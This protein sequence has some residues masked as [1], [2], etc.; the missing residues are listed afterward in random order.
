MNQ[1]LITHEDS[2][3]LAARKRPVLLDPQP[4]DMIMLMVFGWSIF[5]LFLL[6]GG[7][8][9]I[10]QIAKLVRRP[11]MRQMILDGDERV[12]A[13]LMIVGVVGIVILVLFCY[14][15]RLTFAAMAWFGTVYGASGWAPARSLAFPLKYATF[16]FLFVFAG[17]FLLKNFWRLTASP[18][19]RLML[20]YFFWVVG[21]SLAVGGGTTNDLWYIITDLAYVVGFGIAWN[22]HTNDTEKINQYF[23]ALAYTSV[24]VTFFHAI[25]PF[26]HTPYITSGRFHSI[27]GKATGF[28][29]GYAPFVLCLYWMG[30]VH[31]TKLIQ[32]FFTSAALLG[33]LLIFWSGTRSAAAAL[34]C[35]IVVLWWVFRGRI[36]IY[37]FFGA[38]FALLTQII[39]GPESVDITALSSRLQETDSSN[40]QGVW[41][42][43]WGIILNS[44]IYGH[45]LGGLG[46]Q[47]IGEA[48]AS[49]IESYGRGVRYIGAHNA[50]IG[51]TAKFGVIG[52]VLFLSLI[53]HA[54]RPAWT[55][56]FSRS[57]PI[58][59][60]R[61][62]VLAPALVILMCIANLA[63]E[64][65]GSRGRGTVYTTIFYANLIFCALQGSRLLTQY[66]KP[67]LRTHNVEKPSEVTVGDREQPTNNI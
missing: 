17:M 60:K 65:I 36:F 40:R 18:Y 24:A 14:K 56:L 63:E 34:L 23:Y 44:P 39:A 45:G 52:L 1:Q 10:V 61:V 42:Q 62:Y 4:G 41:T 15:Y 11:E 6:A 66:N 64:G 47:F 12:L 59:E 25:A 33:T 55:V 49:L 16:A 13:L 3:A 9:F 53:Y 5:C 26:V 8:R 48:W 46:S 37:I 7:R 35:S 28:G 38:V 54:L 32:Q 51:I 67:M 43:Y 19:L 58:E 30:M 2:A 22:A 29:V 21:I 50:Y 20:F 57:V 31:K 27:V